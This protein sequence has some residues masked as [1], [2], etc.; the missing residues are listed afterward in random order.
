MANPTG[1]GTAD[2]PFMVSP[3]EMLTL[4]QT[5]APNIQPESPAFRNVLSGHM[6]L[7]VGSKI[8]EVATDA[9]ESPARGAASQGQRDLGDQIA[10]LM[11]ARN[12]KSLPVSSKHGART[13]GRDLGDEVADALDRK[14]GRAP[15]AAP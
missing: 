14:L 3:D 9:N 13:A 8:Y 11:E 15:K 10:D 1:T 4:L 6:T 5:K 12:G 2:D 7:H